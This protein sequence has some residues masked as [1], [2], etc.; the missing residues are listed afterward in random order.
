MDA[1]ERATIAACRAGLRRPLTQS[2]ARDGSSGY[3]ELE[4]DGRCF[5]PRC[6]DRLAAVA[7]AIAVDQ[8]RGLRDR[9]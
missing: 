3:V 2:R 5:S 4:C 7:R 6:G 9:V 8:M 1:G